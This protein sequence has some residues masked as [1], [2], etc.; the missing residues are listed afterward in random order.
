MSV[1]NNPL[2]SDSV[3]VQ[4]EGDDTVQ[5]VNP[6]P[7]PQLPSSIETVWDHPLVEI[8][9]EPLTNGLLKEKKSWKCLAVGCGIKRYR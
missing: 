3:S 8:I 7:R 4:P 5:I 2:D 6:P 9:T 1:A